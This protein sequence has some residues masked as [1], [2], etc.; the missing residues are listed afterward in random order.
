MLGEKPFSCEQCE[1][2]FRHNHN[3]RRHKATHTGFVNIY[4]EMVKIAV[5]V[6]D[7]RM[8][9]SLP[10]WKCLVQKLMSMDC[11]V[12]KGRSFERVWIL[13]PTFSTR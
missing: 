8:S 3:L 10:R 9:L 12:Y 11:W 1:M 5:K 4:S 7:H 2:S 6:G 13:D